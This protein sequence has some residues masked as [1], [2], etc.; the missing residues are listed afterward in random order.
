MF[1]SQPESHPIA[2]VRLRLFSYDEVIEAAVVE[3][4]TEDVLLAS[5][6]GRAT[7]AKWLLETE[8]SSK[9]VKLTRA[10]ASAE[11]IQE[12]KDKFSLEASGAS[13]HLISDI[14]N[15]S[16]E[17]FSEDPVMLLHP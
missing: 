13:P 7:L 8:S 2:K 3:D 14:F 10:Q 6:L 9:C 17:F 5:D 4:I 11:K 12:E 1:C 15:F 16:D